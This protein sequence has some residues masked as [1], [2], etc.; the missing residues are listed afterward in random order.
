MVD[1]KNKKY[2]EE[3]YEIIAENVPL[4]FVGGLQHVEEDSDTEE[5]EEKTEETEVEEE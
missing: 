1:K 3:G 4:I 5:E 2:T